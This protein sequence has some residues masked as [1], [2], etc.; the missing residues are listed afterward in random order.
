[1]ISFCMSQILLYE[2]V[3]RACMTNFVN[4]VENSFAIPISIHKVGATV[5]ALRFFQFCFAKRGPH[6]KRSAPPF[7][8]WR[9]QPRAVR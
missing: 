8:N 5:L 4:P 7:L 1:M 3:V 6:P 9:L 2:E